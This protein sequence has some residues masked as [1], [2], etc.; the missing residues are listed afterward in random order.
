MQMMMFLIKTLKGF[1]FQHHQRFTRVLRA[2]LRDDLRGQPGPVLLDV[3]DLCPPD[4]GQRLWQVGG[5]QQSGHGLERHGR[6]QVHQLDPALDG[7]RVRSVTAAV[8]YQ[9]RQCCGG[10]GG[11]EL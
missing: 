6:V 8:L 5:V 1:L 10:G 9:R 7:R 2:Q 4:G 3:Q 11:G